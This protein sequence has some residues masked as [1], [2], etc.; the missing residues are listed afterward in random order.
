M[1]G[2]EAIS[3]CRNRS[4]YEGSTPIPNYFCENCTEALC[5]IHNILQRLSK[6]EEAWRVLIKAT[7]G[8]TSLRDQKSPSPK[9]EAES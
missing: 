7:E 9:K 1:S 2:E 8:E 5:P 6:L 4:W 3:I